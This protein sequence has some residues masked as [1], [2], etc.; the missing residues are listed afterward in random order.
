[1]WSDFFFQVMA[2]IG[3]A[4][5]VIISGLKLL[6][7]ILSDRIARKEQRN[8]D[9]ELERERQEY[10]VRRVQAD[11]FAKSQFDVYLQ[12]W[13]VLQELQLAIDAAWQSASPANVERLVDRIGATEK[14]LNAWSVL[15]DEKQLREIRRILGI[16]QG[17]KAG[18]EYLTQLRFDSPVDD[19]SMRSIQ[20][21][22]E[23]NRALR[24]QFA[25]ALDRLRRVFRDRMAALDR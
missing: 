11:L 10:G 8:I 9:S 6:G 7:T 16:V 24:D 5:V 21:Q 25:T 2:T 4:G 1:M 15:I 18:K 12:L 14:Q 3:G 22:I 19:D 13:A 23:R 20:V 17:F